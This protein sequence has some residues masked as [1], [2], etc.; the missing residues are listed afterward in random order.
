MHIS[1]RFATWVWLALV[2]LTLLTFAI[3]E[4]VTAGKAVMMSVLLISLLKGQLIANYFMG[5][6]HVSWLWRGIIL[7][8]FVIVGSMVAVAYLK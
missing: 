8:Y 3:G 4:E 1:N 2:I 5:L 6:R 7:G